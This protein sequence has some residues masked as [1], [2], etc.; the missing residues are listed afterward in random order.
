M[1]PASDGFKIALNLDQLLKSRLVFGPI[2]LEVDSTSFP[3]FGWTDFPVAILGFWLVNIQPML[4]GR[5]ESC[6]CPFMDGPYVFRV[7]VSSHSEWKLSMFE[8]SALKGNPVGVR[9]LPSRAVLNQ[10]ITTAEILLQ[11]CEEKDWVDQDA[12]T[13]KD[14]LVQ[15]KT[16][17]EENK[18]TDE[19]RSDPRSSV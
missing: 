8:D 9:I 17:L 13:L 4:L 1:S 2:W 7:E 10:L 19:R 3:G 14:S 5:A 12:A 16:I 6:E 15:V 11:K 18:A